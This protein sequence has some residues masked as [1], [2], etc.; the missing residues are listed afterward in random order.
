MKEGIIMKKLFLAFTLL[1]VFFLAACA[2]P[3]LS[4]ETPTYDPQ[5]ASTFITVDINPS[6]TFTLDE[7]G[8]ITGY[9]L[10]NEDA[11]IVA[12]DLTFIG[13]TY[14]DA[15][16]LFLDAAI[17]TGYVDVTRTDNVVVITIT[18]EAEAGYEA[19]QKEVQ[20][21]IAEHLSSSG[22]QAAVENGAEYYED[23][24]EQAEANDV[25]VGQIILI[26]AA[27]QNDETLT[28]EAALA[29][30]PEVLR[31]NLQADFQSRID[32]YRA[33]REEEASVIKDEIKALVEA[34]IAEYEAAVE[35]GEIVP[36]ESREELKDQLIE[37]FRQF[38]E[39]L[40][41]L[42]ESNQSE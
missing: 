3:T 22:I 9:V 18:Q 37:Q 33:E 21:K 7:D 12:A 27:M 6:I 1:A 35:A 4:N 23:I 40:E 36:P 42:R 19:F 30:D 32:A 28:F 29:T 2:E 17:E 15:L 8:V 11:E 31:E 25:S 5:D 16:A 14:D 38:K 26:R 41:A 10:S 13:L 20:A 34:R 39:E 24:R